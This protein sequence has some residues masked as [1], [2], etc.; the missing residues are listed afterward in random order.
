MGGAD[1]QEMVVKGKELYLQLLSATENLLRCFDTCAPQD[2]EELLARRQEI[3]TEFQ[4]VD[5]Q[6]VGYL[7]SLT[8]PMERDVELVWEEF[9]LFQESS[10]KRILELDALVIALARERCKGIK[11]DLAAL[12][13][14]KAAHSA[15]ER[16]SWR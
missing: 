8:G 5:D 2:L 14:K 16:R 11:G 7:N 4:A 12:V 3:I 10:T 9:R 13:V 6:L 15:Y 1:F